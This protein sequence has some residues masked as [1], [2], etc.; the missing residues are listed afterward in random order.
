MPVRRDAAAPARGE[1]TVR[2]DLDS[3]CGIRAMCAIRSNQLTICKTQDDN[4]V[5]ARVPLSELQVTL[6][7]HRQELF[8]LASGCCNV[9]DDI[10]CCVDSEDI[11]NE[12]LAVFQRLGIDVATK[13]GADD[14]EHVDSWLSG[15]EI[16]GDALK[17]RPRPDWRTSCGDLKNSRRRWQQCG[18]TPCHQFQR[19]LHEAT[20][21][22]ISPAQRQKRP[23]SSQGRRPCRRRP[24]R[25][26]APHPRRSRSA[27]AGSLPVTT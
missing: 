6:W 23:T 3:E 9:D 1:V 5:F 22:N 20:P 16:N 19:P 2:L 25:P 4:A 12:W 24:R 17:A 10:V 13:L 27:G 18:R 21:S 26:I 11:W 14:E 8:G 7:P 15:V